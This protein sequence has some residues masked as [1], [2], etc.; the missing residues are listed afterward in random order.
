MQKEIQSQLNS[1]INVMMEN[2]IN[3]RQVILDQDISLSNTPKISIVIPTLKNNVKIPQFLSNCQ[4]ILSRSPGRSKGRND[5]A[6]KCN[7]EFILFIDDDAFFNEETYKKYILN[8]FK[9]EP[10]TVISYESTVLCTRVMGISKNLFMILGGFDETFITA[11]DHDF[12]YRVIE[13]GYKI[14]YIPKELI[15]HREHIRPPKRLQFLRSWRNHVRLMLRYK[16]LLIWSKRYNIP[17]NLYD[18][19]MMFFKAPKKGFYIPMRVI[20]SILSF[21]YYFFFDKK[22]LIHYRAR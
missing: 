10:N 11:E 1:Q 13:K 8:R 21:Y 7:F 22:K 5:G 15:F 16:K 19:F 20:I 12:G 6:M 9:K 3:Q 18:F 14:S 17:I 4:I 2:D